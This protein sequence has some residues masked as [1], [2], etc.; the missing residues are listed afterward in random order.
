[1]P[2]VYQIP[3]P[4]QLPEFAKVDETL[5]DIRSGNLLDFTRPTTTLLDRMPFPNL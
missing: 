2:K 3:H 4:S 1:M 5:Q